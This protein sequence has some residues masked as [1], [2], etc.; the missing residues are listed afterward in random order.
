[1]ALGA[2]LGVGMQLHAILLVLFPVTAFGVLLVSFRRDRQWFARWGVVFGLCMLLNLGQIIGE[3]QSGFHNSMIFLDSLASSQSDQS[4]T[5][6]RSLAIANDISCHLE[7]NM[8]VLTSVGNG[9][10]GF[11]FVRMF[12]P[13]SA[14]AA[15]YFGHFRIKMWLI[16]TVLFSLSGYGLLL[17]R[18]I[19]ERDLVRRHF[20]GLIL[21]FSVLSF[22]VLLP[23]LASAFRYFVH[24][25]FLPL[26]FFG[27]ILEVAL[28]RFSSRA[29]WVWSVA[30]MAG[31]VIMLTNL[32]AISGA[33]R[34]IE[35]QDRIVVGQVEGL[36]SAMTALSGGA[37]REWYY[38][39]TKTSKDM[40]KSLQ[41][42]ALEH[43]ATL[44]RAKDSSEFP[45]GK[46]FFSIDT[47]PDSGA[48]RNGTDNSFEA[49]RK[50]GSLA[51]YRLRP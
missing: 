38:M 11:D 42:I 36:V 45:P 43:G 10:C 13:L 40:Y 19:R 44:M 29:A 8:Y 50:V 4:D 46:P 21:V 31:V 20:L 9:D 15:L 34:G 3:F 25:F 32:M 48:V 5:G 24:M 30:G 7:A 6:G 51:V 1:M 37:E 27:L 12:Q 35:I 33:L 39:E 17:V 23:V 14:K 26:V 41:Y 49:Y 16:L 47:P 28:V 22:G 2:A 18:F